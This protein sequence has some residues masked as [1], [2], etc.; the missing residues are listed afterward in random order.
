MV[1]LVMLLNRLPLSNFAPLVSTV[2]VLA[3][4]VILLPPPQPLVSIGP[5]QTVVTNNPKLGVHTRLSDEVEEWKIQRTLQMVREMGASWIVEYFPW[6]YSESRKGRFDFAHADLVVNHARAQGLTV[7]AR[8]DL[9]PDWARP[10]GAP[11]NLLTSDHVG[12]YA[13]FVYAFVQHFKGRIYAVQ[14][15]NEPNLNSEWGGR[16]ADPQAY[17]DVLRAAYRRAH[18]ADPNIVVLAGALSPTLEADPS[19]ALDDLD[20]LSAMYAAGARD[21]FDALAIHA[22]GLR[23]AS[24]AQPAP[25]AINFRRAE[26][27]R[28]VM[29]QNGDAKKA[30]FIT[31]G[32]WNDHPRWVFAVTPAQRIAYTLDAYQIGQRDWSWCAVMALWAF[33]FPAEQHSIQDYFTFVTPQFVA[34][35]IYRAVQKATHD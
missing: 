21:T 10:A 7:I 24:D 16:A 6:A 1:R 12:D 29:V 27:L 26:L 3:A 2:I 5:Q 23:A 11:P 32:G 9:V 4:L 30:A 28:A 18:E 34:K 25:D 22:Y 17:T 31:E 15:W 20:Y 19:R 14:I 33:R 8:V 13:D 35:P